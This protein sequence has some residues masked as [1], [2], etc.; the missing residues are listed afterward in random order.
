M[1]FDYKFIVLIIVNSHVVSLIF[2]FFTRDSK[3]D[4]LHVL[5]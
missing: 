2:T 3:L 5:N 4:I 1:N